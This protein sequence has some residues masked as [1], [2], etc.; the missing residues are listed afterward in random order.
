MTGVM[1]MK[2]N[3]VVDTQIFF[4]QRI[5]GASVYWYELLSRAAADDEIDLTLLV[6][7]AEYD[8]HLFSCL[9]FSRIRLVR[10]RANTLNEMRLVRPIVPHF[11]KNPTVF[12]S[13][14]MRLPAS[15]TVKRV[16]T[17]HDFT[18]QKFFSLWHRLPNSFFKHRAIEEADGIISISRSTQNDLY[19]F[20]PR[21]ALKPNVI[22]YN[23]VSDN[24]C[25]LPEADKVFDAQFGK[26]KP[27]I[28]FVGEREGYKNFNFAVDVVRRVSGVEL[29]VVGGAPFTPN[30]VVGMGE[31]ASRTRYIGRITNE[32]LNVLY[33]KANALIYP[34]KYEGFGLPIAEAMRAGCPVIALKN[35]SIPEVA[36]CAGIL[37]DKGDVA[38]G[39][40]AVSALL[41]NDYRNM[42][43]SGGIDQGLSFNWDKCY[44]E[45]KKFYELICVQ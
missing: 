11:D 28:L 36:G 17:I 44:K 35:S 32:A 29:W 2:I 15:R 42:V 5:G 16:I 6:A 30:E 12:H 13:S 7:D 19:C 39:A 45:V 43:G 10:E 34:S 37:V 20:D 21:A 26:W 27:F 33:N 8:N 3:L 9:D 4:A 24:Y 1:L 41:N 18:H 14:Y 31:V 38:A 22:I 40:R 23:G 25:V